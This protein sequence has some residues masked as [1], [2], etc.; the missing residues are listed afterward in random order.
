M[1]STLCAKSFAYVQ[2]HQKNRDHMSAC[3]HV[4]VSVHMYRITSLV[5]SNNK[6]TVILLLM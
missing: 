1:V 6:I 4:C 2:V 5:K 3:M